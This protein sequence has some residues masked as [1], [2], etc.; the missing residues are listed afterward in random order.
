MVVKFVG[1]VKRDDFRLRTK[2]PYLKTRIFYFGDY[3]YGIYIENLNNYP[4]LNFNEL[5]DEFD[6]RIRILGNP[7]K[8]I[9]KMPEQYI[10]EIET[11]KDSKMAENFEGVFFT[12]S[13]FVNFLKAKYNNYEIVD[14]RT[15]FE[16]QKFIVILDYENEHQKE[17]LQVELNKLVLSFDFEI[18][19][20]NKRESNSS[21]SN[22][23]FGSSIL[24]A[25]TKIDNIL[26]IPAYNMQP[27]KLEFI[28]RDES[29]W[30]ENIDKVYSGDFTK[31]NLKFFDKDKTSCFVDYTGAPNIDIRNVL[32]MYD[33]IY[34][35]IPFKDKNELLFNNTFSKEDL[36]LLIEKNRVKLINIQPE[37]RLDT[38]IL[39]EAYQ[40]QPNS[41][42]NRRALSL[43]SIIDFYDMNKNS[44]FNDTELIP[45]F[46]DIA[47]GI[48]KE[49]NVPMQEILQFINWPQQA[50]RESF[51]F[52]NSNGIFAYGYMG[53]NNLIQDK[54]S[55]ILNKDLTLEFTMTSH[56]I[57]LANALNATFFPSFLYDEK[58]KQNSFEAPYSNL[59]GALLNFYKY[60]SRDTI[61]SLANIENLKLNK[62][63]L[64]S[65]VD[66]F[67][68]NTYVSF[69]EFEK[70]TSSSTVRN[71]LNVLFNKLANMNIEERKLEVKRYNELISEFQKKNK[72]KLILS[73]ATSDL[74]GGIVPTILTGNIIPLIIFS[75][76]NSNLIKGLITRSA[77]Y[78]Y[79]QDAI[80]NLNLYIRKQE[81]N[82]S[83]IDILS[84]INRVAKIK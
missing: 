47:K 82:L 45:V 38:D 78:Q 26:Q 9:D 23:D 61:A 32:L 48:S 79:I 27:V 64:V 5:Q 1:N 83:D 81:G 65:P 7:T 51:E 70:Y 14:V 55:K 69:E 19:K 80:K 66:I 62:Q 41:V 73:D 71:R 28:K 17:M 21:N 13:S 2:Y 35:T 76:F 60:A 58:G 4:F 75:I 15:D 40:I 3:N 46:N 84:Q 67:D 57:H 6:N 49:L 37:E 39:K 24:N 33:N 22:N 74:L 20:F 36:F 77:Q 12:Q 63:S 53:I 29:L 42:I 43:L 18:E 59:M 56:N 68:V 34:L 11:I 8:I 25:Y 16:K 50:L 30:F 52:F 72:M 44:I 54:L 10:E 31:E